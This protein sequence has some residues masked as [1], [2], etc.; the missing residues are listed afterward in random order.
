MI[1]GILESS[2]PLG[3]I[4]KENNI[5]QCFLKGVHMGEIN[6]SFL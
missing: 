3:G 2:L 4:Y 6:Y 5:I 1:L